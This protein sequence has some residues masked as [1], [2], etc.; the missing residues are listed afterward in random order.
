MP[1][2]D[3]MRQRTC[4]RIFTWSTATTVHGSIHVERHIM[5]LTCCLSKMFSS[6][7]INSAVDK[8]EVEM[9]FFRFYKLP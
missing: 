8:C 9:S 1:E 6:G 3:E 2:V 7:H 4:R 5:N